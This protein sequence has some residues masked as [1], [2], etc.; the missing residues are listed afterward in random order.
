MYNYLSHLTDKNTKTDTY[1]RLLLLIKSLS[2]YGWNEIQK[3]KGVCKT[4][5]IIL[6]MCVC[7]YLLIYRHGK[8]PS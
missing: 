8:F 4:W 7:I 3:W 6:L 5:L 1:R 2:M